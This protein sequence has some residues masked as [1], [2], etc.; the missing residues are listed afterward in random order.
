[1]AN[2]LRNSSRVPFDFEDGL[3]INGKNIEGDT[4]ASLIGHKTA[5]LTSK[6]LDAI[7]S[8]I[9]PITTDLTLYLAVTGSDTTGDGT[10]AKPWYSPHKALEWLSTRACRNDVTVM[11][12]MG[13]GE[14]NFTKPIYVKSIGRNFGLHLKGANLLGTAPNLVNNGPDS[15]TF[16]THDTLSDDEIV[17]RALIKSRYATV[18]NFPDTVNGFELQ[19][20]THLTISNLALLGPAN[21]NSGNAVLSFG[22]KMTDG[23]PNAIHGFRQAMTLVEKSFTKLENTTFSNSKGTISLYDNSSFV[24]RNKTIVG[25]LNGAGGIGFDQS[26]LNFSGITIS[27][28]MGSGIFGRESQVISGGAATEISNCKGHGIHIYDGTSV[29]IAN[30]TIKNIARHGVM[31]SNARFAAYGLFISDIGNKGFNLTNN[32][33]ANVSGTGVGVSDRSYITK[34]GLDALYLERGGYI[35]FNGE[36]YG[37][38]LL[39]SNTTPSVTCN[40]G[41]Y[42]YLAQGSIISPSATAGNPDIK[43]TG[44]G[45][46]NVENNIPGVIYSPTYATIGNG[47]AYINRMG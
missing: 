47:N 46:I 12:L 42:I 8:D 3:I 34:C 18:L 26:M 32:S 33:I 39:K 38:N 23:G 30:T 22:G 29:N 35:Y 40:G 1:M 28:C 4:G 20:G 41:G 37:N 10:S 27:G 36:I 2:K 44:N 13:A 7:L 14:Y 19:S 25:F 9:E 24:F 16:T 21:G 31:I 5:Q 43:A 15:F 6:K 45:Y 11:I 17:N